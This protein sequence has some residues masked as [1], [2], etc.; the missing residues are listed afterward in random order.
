MRCRIF[1]P[2]ITVVVFTTDLC[3]RIAVCRKTLLSPRAPHIVFGVVLL[4]A[5]ARQKKLTH[6]KTNHR[7]FFVC[8]D[9]CCKGFT[10]LLTTYSAVVALCAL[11]AAIALSDFSTSC[12]PPD[13]KAASRASQALGSVR[14]AFGLA[15][16]AAGPRGLGSRNSWLALAFRDFAFAFGN[17]GIFGLFRLF[18]VNLRFLCLC[19]SSVLLL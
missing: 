11:A 14:I 5:H 15:A 10:S 1:R 17:L 16:L 8:G 9:F 4:I 2:A 13:T 7:L 18:A 3:T 19:G 6:T 12:D